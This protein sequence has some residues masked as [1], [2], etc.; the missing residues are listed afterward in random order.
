VKISLFNTIKLQLVMPVFL[1]LFFITACDNNN[2]TLNISSAE[3]SQLNHDTSAHWL[4]TKLILLPKSTDNNDYILLKTDNDKNESIPLVMSETPSELQIKYPHLRDFQAYHLDI[5]TAEAKQWLKHQLMVVAFNEEGK[6]QKVA[7]VQTGPVLDALY[8]QSKHDADEENALGAT[9]AS[10]AINFKL[11]APTAQKVSVLIFDKQSFSQKENNTFPKELLQLTMTE[12]SKTGI[13]HAQGEASLTHHYYQYQLTVYH[14][15][16]KKV[17]TLTTTDPYSLSLSV[18]SK[19]SQIVDLNDST[20]QPKNWVNHKIPVV[21]HV[22]DNIF[23]EMHIRDFSAIDNTLS[24]EKH[25]GKYKAFSE[26]SSDGIKH[27]KALKEAGLNNI[28]LLPTFDIATVNEGSTQVIDLN[29]SMSKLCKLVP[30]ISICQPDHSAN[31]KAGRTGNEVLK[32]NN[33]LLE[34]DK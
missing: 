14:P 31:F 26:Q 22:E 8:T 20:T 25:R 19:Y 28:H 7:Y 21:K 2:S 34:K 3:L 27:L 1:I 29:D 33:D 5:T 11:W 24:D 15:A 4:T 13:W 16:S 30:S 32:M 6:A 23:Y 10:K 17:E 12:D 9:I 18:N